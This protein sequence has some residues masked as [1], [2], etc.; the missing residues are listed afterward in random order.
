MIL[1]DLANERLREELMR[2]KVSKAGMARQAAASLVGSRI[3]VLGK[4]VL[5]TWHKL[6]KQLKQENELQKLREEVM[7]YRLSKEGLARQAAAALFGSG[8][9]AL[10]KE[11][12]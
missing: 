10:M 7:Q 6:V 3:T 8:A 1:R 11:A 4:E 5:S 9:N 2:Y 12:I